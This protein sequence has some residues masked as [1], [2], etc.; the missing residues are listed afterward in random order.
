M[1]HMRD[2]LLEHLGNVVVVQRVDDLAPVATADDQPEVAHQPELMR[3]G[4]PSIPT[5]A[6]NSPTGADPLCR[7]AR[8]RSRLGVASACI[9]SAAAWE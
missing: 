5:A 1:L 7:R 2:D 8:I 3:D 9:A 6:A 4:E